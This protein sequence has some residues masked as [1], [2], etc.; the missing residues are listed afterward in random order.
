MDERKDNTMMAVLQG[1][2]LARGRLASSTAAGC[3]SRPPLPAQLIAGNRRR[4][5]WAF[6]DRGG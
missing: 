2:L 5:P 6:G 3:L 4:T 1:C